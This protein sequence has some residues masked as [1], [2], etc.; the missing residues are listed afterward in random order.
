MAEVIAF[1]NGLGHASDPDF[2]FNSEIAPLIGSFGRK[3]VN[4]DNSRN[5]SGGR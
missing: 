3:L 1:R 4:L 5:I 2:F